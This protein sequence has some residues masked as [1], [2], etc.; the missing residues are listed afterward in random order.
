ME[1]VLVASSVRGMSCSRDAVPE[2]FEGGISGVPTLTKLNSDPDR[3]AA[4]SAVDM[5]C[6][7]SSP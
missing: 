7:R 3:D 5:V 6:H 1:S 2:S 4:R